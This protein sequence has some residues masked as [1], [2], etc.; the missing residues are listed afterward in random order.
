MNATPRGWTDRR[1]DR[2]ASDDS[3]LEQLERLAHLL[4]TR[5]QVPGTGWRFGIDGIAGLLPGVG[6]TAT[7][8]VS[9]YLIWQA[10]RMGV[11]PGLLLRMAG[12]VGLDVVLGSVPVLGSIFDFAFKANRRNLRLLRR[13]LDRK[14]P[15]N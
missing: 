5:W 3:R 6:D 14:T 7:G 11:P 4:D 1:S 15:R 10:K 12:N 13:H 9:V 2:A 8:L